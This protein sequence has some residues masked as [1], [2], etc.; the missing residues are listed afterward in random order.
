MVVAEDGPRD[1]V[2][3]TNEPLVISWA[4]ADASRVAQRS[5]WV[6]GS[7][8]AQTYGLYGNAFCG[9]FG[10]QAVGTHTFA[11]LVAD[12]GGGTQRYEGT[13]N[14]APLPIYQPP[15]G[16]ISTYVVYYQSPLDT[17]ASTGAGQRN[18]SVAGT[19]SPLSLAA[20]DAVLADLDTLLNQSLA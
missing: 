10:P 16:G 12:A 3:T 20:T 13:V 11:I 14:V 18:G 19:P 17:S 6:D 5:L 8:V 1:S 2:L 9:V 7:L 15:S 4:V